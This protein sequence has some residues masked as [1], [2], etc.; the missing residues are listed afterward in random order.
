MKI[1]PGRQMMTG[2]FRPIDVGEWS[3][4][5]Y[6]GP[7][8]KLFNAIASH[9]I[10]T[11]EQAVAE[12]VDINR[13]DYVGRTALQMAIMVKAL[14]IVNFLIDNGARMTARLVD[15]RTCLH[16]AANLDLPD[17]VLKLLE[18]SRWNEEKVKEAEEAAKNAAMDT[19]D[20]EA[21]TRPSS[22]DDW[23][24]DENDGA[25]DS[26][27]IAPVVNKYQ[28]PLELT[29]LPEDEV[30]KPDIIDVNAVDWDM[31]FTPL[32]YA[33]VAGSVR[34][35]DILL[36]AGAQY[37]LES[38]EQVVQHYG[39][40]DNP[41][42]HPLL[43]PA[44]TMDETSS[45]AITERLIRAGA[46]TSQADGNKFTILHSLIST[47]KT[48]L[49]EA[50]L[51]NDPNAKA[52]LNVVYLDFA[53]AI[54]PLV[55]AL[56]L[57]KP[58]LVALLLLYGSD[59]II[60]KEDIEKAILPMYIANIHEFKIKTYHNILYQPLETAIS[61]Y[62]DMV[63][64]LAQIGADVSAPAK[65]TLMAVY[66]VFS[67]CTLLDWVKQYLPV[68]K[69][70]RPKTVIRI[71]ESPTVPKTW[72]EHRGALQSK[73][74][75]FR[76]ECQEKENQQPVDHEENLRKSRE[77]TG[78]QIKYLE[79]LLVLL[80]RS[81]AKEW[82]D[83]K[84]GLINPAALPKDYQK[85]QP[86]TPLVS[87][88]RI[89]SDMAIPSAPPLNYKILSTSGHQEFV[90]PHQRERYHALFEACW[91]GDNKTIEELCLPSSRTDTSPTPLQIT[92]QSE[93][94]NLSGDFAYRQDMDGTYT[95]FGAA[96]TARKWST[97][98]LILGIAAAQYKKPDE[99]DNVYYPPSIE[100][101]A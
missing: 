87:A 28:A 70:G 99:P 69:A 58:A 90:S 46:S 19:D 45:I 92:V 52:A 63:G 98:K 9:D 73:L 30:D 85:N 59:V 64:L 25:E 21:T 81:G 10:R 94:Y 23:S 65:Y 11:V 22:E 57:Q 29:V 20:G 93:Q 56:A 1:D 37:K 40:A 79:D 13:R 15:G 68:L 101:S 36:A 33:I 39:E 100:L 91:T 7:I 18:R 83:I 78:R 88:L 49:V 42:L 96:V 17:V 67:I 55:T 89:P 3:E 82:K 71:L 72:Q 97:A 84:D 50:V 86:L 16:L 51:R 80:E 32:I 47:G 95:P 74:E 41:V 31:A 66:D 34:C 4:Q 76:K 77:A 60:T 54:H 24:S 6:V 35:V 5:A 12:G 14:D 8:E 75:H 43:M 62:S 44:L 61:T 53:N 2:S 48:H 26:K 38:V 27:P